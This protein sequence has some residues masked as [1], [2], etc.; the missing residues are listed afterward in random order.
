MEEYTMQKKNSKSF[1]ISTVIYIILLLGMVGIWIYLRTGS[2]TSISN[3]ID[4]GIENEITDLKWYDADGNDVQDLSDL[5]MLDEK[6]EISSVLPADLPE[7]KALCFRAK[8]TVFS[9]YLD[10][11]MIYGQE[12]PESPL[13][14]NSNGATWN[15]V[16]LLKEYA[17]REITIKYELCYNE[18]G[19]GFDR[20][21]ICSEKDF[22]L[23]VI[24]SKIPALSLSFTYMVLGIVLVVVDL[25]I[26]KK[27]N[28]SHNLFY[29]GFIAIS[30]AAYC[31]VE[32]QVFQI[33]ISDQKIM[34]LLSIFSMLAVPIPV[35]MYAETLFDFKGKYTSAVL[36]FAVLIVFVVTTVMNATGVMDYHE[37]M[38]AIH[39]MLI[40]AFLIMLYSIIRYMYY[41]KKKKTVFDPCILFMIAGL[42]LIILCGIVDV[43][44]FYTVKTLDPALFTRIGFLGTIICFFIASSRKILDVF[45]LNTKLEVVT[46]LAYEDGLTGLFNRTSYKEKLEEYENNKI[47]FGIVM[48]D[49]NNLKKV[50]DNFG[51]D[52]GDKM[53]VAAAHIIKNAF[54]KPGMECFRIGGD[55]F[56]VLV[57]TQDIGRDCNEGI[58]RLEI[59][60][61]EYNSGGEHRFE[62]VIA[63]GFNVYKPEDGV[64]VKKAVQ[65]A[66]D[67]MYKN[68]QELKGII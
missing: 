53:L 27:M 38:T 29:L 5:Y 40:V 9:V 49:V 20:M 2:K 37:S 12:L 35:L 23:D 66:D 15:T 13:Y 46:R 45:K 44:R 65:A 6:G 57:R 54:D 52:E 26:S 24:R 8:H 42:V 67:L 3:P 62:L 59:L 61:D 16:P 4:E 14:T 60:Y 33:F 58:A 30:V 48:M 17:G 51:H 55:E 50:N 39:V 36:S 25:I 43:I 34:H 68:K 19:C 7:G 22:I 11:E 1:I 28:L 63:K 41:V 31:M 56:V 32:T 47:S 64:A 18:S 10:D 21:C